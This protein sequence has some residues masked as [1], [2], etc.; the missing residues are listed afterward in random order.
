MHRSVGLITLIFIGRYDDR[1]TITALRQGEWNARNPSGR[2]SASMNWRTVSRI[3]FWWSLSEKS[4]V[5]LYA[6]YARC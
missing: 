3:R 4:I 2:T 6:G 1:I 5:S